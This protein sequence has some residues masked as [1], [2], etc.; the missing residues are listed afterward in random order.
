[1]HAIIRWA[2]WASQIYIAGPK[3][4]QKVEELENLDIGLWWTLYT[5]MCSVQCCGSA[6]KNYG[7][8]SYI[9]DNTLITITNT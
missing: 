1:M 7:C 8:D 6:E 9:Q 4:Q 3:S 5:V 2:C